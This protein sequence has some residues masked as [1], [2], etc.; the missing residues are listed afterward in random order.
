VILASQAADILFAVYFINETS[1][2]QSIVLP[3]PLGRVDA[4]FRFLTTGA[5]LTALL[6]GVLGGRSARAAIA[7]GV[8]GLVGLPVGIRP[9]PRRVRAAPERWGEAPRESVVTAA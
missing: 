9:P 1:L 5:G 4:S 3:R 6:G 8:L 2:R 7:V